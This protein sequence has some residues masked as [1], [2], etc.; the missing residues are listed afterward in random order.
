MKTIYL[1]VN[2]EGWMAFDYEAETTKQELESRGITIGDYAKIGHSAKIGHYAEIGDYAK[3][4][5]YAEIGH[6][7]KIG[8]SAK[9]GHYAEIGDYAKIGHSATIGDKDIISKTI[10]ITG[11]KHTVSFWGRN[12]INIGCQ[13][14]DI[15]WWLEHYRGV[16]KLEGYTP[17]QIDEYSNYIT[18]CKMMQE[19]IDNKVKK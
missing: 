3:I 18:I 15:N 2:N 13:K 7:S 5:D 14:H 10:F 6:S 8:H 11:T 12:I 9:I 17:E 4:G 19:Q 1:W 16:G